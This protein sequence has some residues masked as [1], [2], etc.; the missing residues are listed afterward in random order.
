MS[1]EWKLLKTLKAKRIGATRSVPTVIEVAEDPTDWFDV[2]DNVSLKPGTTIV[3]E[4]EGQLVRATA[5]DLVRGKQV[6]WWGTLAASFPELGE[7]DYILIEE[8][9]P[10][11]LGPSSR[12]DAIHSLEPNEHG[13]TCRAAQLYVTFNLNDSMRKDGLADLSKVAL[14]VDGKDVTRLAEARGTISLPQSLLSLLYRGEMKVGVHTATVWYRDDQGKPRS[15]TWSFTV[16][17]NEMKSNRNTW[18]CPQ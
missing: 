15:Y 6:K 7:A 5:R 9:D 8:G 2:D 14:W 17:R 16:K 13:E 4:D 10:L 12:P 11:R 3:K 18:P 1:Q